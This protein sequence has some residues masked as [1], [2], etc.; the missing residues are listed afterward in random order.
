MSALVSMARSFTLRSWEAS[1]A[2]ESPPV[3]LLLRLPMSTPGRSRLAASRR[4]P[5]SVL[6]VSVLLTVVPVVGLTVTLLTWR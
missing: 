6:G 5:P 3:R 2:E 4:K 1:T